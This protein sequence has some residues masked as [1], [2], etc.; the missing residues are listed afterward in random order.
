MVINVSTP[1]SVALP[2]GVEPITIDCGRAK[3]AALQAGSSPAVILVP[4]FTGSKEDFIPLL[5]KLG[6]SGVSALAIDLLGQFQSPGP[7]DP[8]A[9]SITSWAHDLTGLSQTLGSCVHLVGHSMGGLICRQ[10][11]LDT[12]DSVASLVLMSS[13]PAALPSAA[14]PLI[15]TLLAALPSLS[16]Q[17]IWQAKLK[18]DGPPDP[19]TSSEVAAFLEKRWLMNTPASLAGMAQLL[20]QAPDRTQELRETAWAHGIPMLVTYGVDDSAAWPPHL[21]SDM[22]VRLGVPSVPIPNAAHSPAIE[23]PDATLAA[24]IEF[25]RFA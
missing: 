21:Q 14:H 20:L 3:L 2:L 12:P 15:Q 6:E 9:Y 1:Q 10:A 19:Q 13:G 5:G 25:W 23:N 18:L 16:L 4:G 8:D 7:T 24:M 17:Q 11:L 22:A